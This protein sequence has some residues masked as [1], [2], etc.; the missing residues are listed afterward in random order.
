MS[1]LKKKKKI[2]Q[3]KSNNK[4][5]KTKK[6]TAVNVRK[7]TLFAYIYYLLKRITI[8]KMLFFRRL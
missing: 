4:K 3:K 6:E 5:A 8:N 1:H 2:T 7:G